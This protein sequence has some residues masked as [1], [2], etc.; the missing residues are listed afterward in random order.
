[1]SELLIPAG[2]LW[3]RLRRQLPD[4]MVTAGWRRWP[5]LL[6]PGRLSL[7][8]ARPW[9]PQPVDLAGGWQRQGRRWCR[10]W[11]GWCWWLSADGCRLYVCR[12]R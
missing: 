12:Q 9:A 3:Q 6:H 1:M 2:R 10:Q 4:S 8:L 5:A 7:E 11:A